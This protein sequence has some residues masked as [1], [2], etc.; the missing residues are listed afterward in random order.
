VGVLSARKFFSVGARTESF[1]PGRVRSFFV[2]SF[3]EGLGRCDE[4]EAVLKYRTEQE[5]QFYDGLVKSGQNLIIGG[6]NLICHGF[7]LTAGGSE[8][9]IWS[10]RATD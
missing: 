2:P 3:L 7:F 6:L 1:C 9:Y 8:L 5:L 4:N 10:D